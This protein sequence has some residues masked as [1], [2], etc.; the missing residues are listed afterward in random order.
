M[1]VTRTS[2]ASILSP[3]LYFHLA[4]DKQQQQQQQKKNQPRV[5][6]SPTRC[7][8]QGGTKKKPRERGMNKFALIFLT[9]HAP[10][11]APHAPFVR[12]HGWRAAFI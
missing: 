2:S 6:M 7:S 1:R 8:D 9:D 4:A 10:V 5:Q 3:S 12:T 11:L